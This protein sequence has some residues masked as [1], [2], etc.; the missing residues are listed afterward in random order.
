[1]NRYKGLA[2]SLIGLG[3][4]A[5][6]FPLYEQVKYV[7]SSGDESAVKPRHVLIASSVSKVVASSLF[8]PHEVH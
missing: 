1:M 3:H 5:V 4:V 8:Y 2:P 6:Q 7:L